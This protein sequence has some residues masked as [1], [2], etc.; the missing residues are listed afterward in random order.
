MALFQ[1]SVVKKYLSQIDTDKLKPFFDKYKQFYQDQERI[2][3]IRLLKEE[4]YQEGFLR[5]FFC[6]SLG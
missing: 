4:N 3:N 5:E 2:N 1:N 6:D